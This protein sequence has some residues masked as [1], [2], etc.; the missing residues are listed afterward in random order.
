M[1]ASAAAPDSPA[2]APQALLELDGVTKQFP[3]RSAG[4][5]G[6]NRETVQAVDGVSLAVRRGETL[7][8]VGETGC[9]KS[10]LARCITRLYDLTAGTVTFGGD[11]IS[12]LSARQLRPYRRKM[13]MVFQD[14]YGSLNP[15]RRGGSPT[16]SRPTS[17][18]RARRARPRCRS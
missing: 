16:R 8:L 7:G 12:R 1:T 5:L 10:T 17:S 11:D 18:C 3:V 9:G 2:G 6:R 13:Q 14:P 4:L 15:R